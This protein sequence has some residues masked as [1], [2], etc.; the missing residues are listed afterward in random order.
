MYVWQRK[1][2]SIMDLYHMLYITSVFL[3]KKFQIYI[4]PELIPT[5]KEPWNLEYEDIGNTI[6][7]CVF[8]KYLELNAWKLNYFTL[9][10]CKCIKDLVL[11]LLLWPVVFE[12][13][14]IKHMEISTNL[15][16]N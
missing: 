8:M 15:L 2:H 14:A 13:F 6:S 11:C 9:Y 7:V 16:C 3:L 12:I 10:L 4:W 5:S 1:L